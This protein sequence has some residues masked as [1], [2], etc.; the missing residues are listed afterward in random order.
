M[1]SF[2]Q[3]SFQKILGFNNYLFLFS[4]YTSYKIRF[5]HNDKEFRYFIKL[6]NQFEGNAIVDVGANIGTTVAVLAKNYPNYQIIAYEPMTFNFKTL[7]AV[8]KFHAFE[9]VLLFSNAIGETNKE[10]EM[11]TPIYQGVIKHGLSHVKDSH[12]DYNVKLMHQKCQMKSLDYSLMEVKPNLRI[13]AI[14]I[15][16]ENYEYM[17][18]TG[19]QETI[20]QHQPLVFAELWDDDKKTACIEKMQSLGYNAKVLV[21]NQLVN[22][23]NQ[24]CLNYYFIPNDKSII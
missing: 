20:R 22:Y 14:K 1:K 2:I 24:I 17:V 4:L 3:Y 12:S 19:A 21:N 13:S 10:I 15:D 9:N 11:T 7:S 5:F 23:E 18:L 6:I 8:V 16:V